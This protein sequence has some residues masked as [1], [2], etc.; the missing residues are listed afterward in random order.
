MGE[1]QEIDVEID[2][3][4][5]VGNA[6][7]N[8]RVSVLP[9]R[10]Y[11]NTIL[12][13]LVILLVGL[14]VSCAQYKA[15][16]VLTAIAP[17]FGLSDAAA[18]WIMSIFTFVGIFVALPSGRIA[19]KLGFKKAMLLS[20]AVLIAGSIVGLL[21]FDNGIV[22]IVSRGI[23]GAALTCMTLC[24]PIAIRECVPP[25]KM[26]LGNG[27]WGCWGNGGAVIACLLTPQIFEAAGFTGVWLAFTVFSVVA[28]LVFL[29]Y[30]KDPAK[31]INISEAVDAIAQ[32]AALEGGSY[33]EFLHKDNV[34]FLLAFVCMNLIMLALL[35]LLP[36]ILQLPEKGFDMSLAGFATTLASLLALVASP[37][38]G[39]VADKMGRIKPLLVLT[40][41]VLGPCLFVMYTQT[42]MAFWAA[43]CVLGLVGF[44]CM[45]LLIAGWMQLM[46]RP[47]VVA[48]GM[49]L[50]TLVQCVGQFLGTFLIQLM[51]GPSLENYFLAG[52]V[53]MLVGF[54]GTIAAAMTRIH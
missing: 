54:L 14:S 9:V 12:V 7:E 44:G 41:F 43:V 5:T 39:A 53:L 50:L 24:A 52:I 34:L 29:L 37:V 31:S 38:F 13:S 20:S 28:A 15:S 40:L 22:L 35:G 16:T 30:V 42:G 8:A 19:Q 25:E 23:E 46:P 36:S 18:S 2:E 17:Q 32:E 4:A 21:S 48:K 10:K 3:T 1:R 49:A 27:I 33:R 26:G 6:E 47:Q 45:G 11:Q 51:L